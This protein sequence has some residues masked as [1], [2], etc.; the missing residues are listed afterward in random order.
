MRHYGQ[1]LMVS[2]T[3]RTDQATTASGHDMFV[4][5]LVGGNEIIVDEAGEPVKNCE[6]V[7]GESYSYVRP[8]VHCEKAFN[9]KRLTFP[10]VFAPLDLETD[11]G[12]GPSWRLRLAP[13]KHCIIDEMDVWNITFIDF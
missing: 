6:R 11:A 9:K 1:L 12:S 7:A 8:R 5:L 2:G 3:G 4:K 13:S 10:T